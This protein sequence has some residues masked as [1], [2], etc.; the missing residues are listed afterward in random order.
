[1]N[2]NTLKHASRALFGLVAMV[3]AGGALA[4]QIPPGADPGAIQQRQV[5]EQQRLR[6]EQS[7]LQADEG[8]AVDTASVAPESGIPDREDIRF[9]VNEFRF[10]QSAILSN[11]EIESIVGPYTG[12]E[13]S[14]ADLRQ[15]MNAINILYREKGVVTAQAVLPPQDLSA[16]NIEIRLIE[17][18]VGQF[19]LEGNRSTRDE[20]ILGQMHMATGDLVELPVLERDLDRFNRLY[21]VRLRAELRP[22]TTVGET[23]VLLLAAE[24]RRHSIRASADNTGNAATGR[25]RLGVV[26]R[27]LSVRGVRDDL[28]VSMT[29][30]D[31]HRGASISY[32][33]P[34]GD[35][36]T[37]L[38]IG[39]FHDKTE[40]V[41]GPV[42]ALGVTGSSRAWVGSLRH[43]FSI[44]R[45]HRLDA[46]L[47]LKTRS[48]TTLLEGVLLQDAEIRDIS[49]GLDGQRLDRWGYWYGSTTIS[50]V[51]SEQLQQAERTFTIYRG[52]INRTHFISERF[53]FVARSSWQ[54]SSGDA[55]PS[56]EQFL[57]GGVGSVRGYE[58]GQFGGD[59]GWVLNLELHHP[60]FALGG[61]DSTRIS[62]F[63]FFDKGR[64]YPFR[65]PNDPQP[66]R[67]SI[68]GFGWGMNAVLTDAI[69][70]TATIGRGSA[71]YP[72]VRHRHFLNFQFVL[73]AL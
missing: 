68:H 48:P 16:G 21:D 43:P 3:F 22:G 11:S 56:S 54:Y 55:Q 73:K 17:G 23:D 25:S 14:L 29:Q 47:G 52:S 6:E 72:E 62:G 13:I 1:M 41:R 70:L 2:N 64:T 36:G 57:I 31:G 7:R 19:L 65:A 71:R 4:Q 38:Q 53:S 33:H 40:L 15:M 10:T 28:L 42:A 59:K 30:S 60:I 12:R 61:G 34:L 51:R 20:F 5:E 9:H 27:N 45:T 66:E 50:R 67:Y 49:I 26:Y 39:F 35:R 44:S 63:T 46:T 18:R 24:P 69:N 37:R 58:T 32:A 8:D